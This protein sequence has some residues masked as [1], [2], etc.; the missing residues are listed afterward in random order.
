MVMLVVVTLTGCLPAQ[1]FLTTDAPALDLIQATT[2]VKAADEVKSAAFTDG[3]ADGLAGAFRGRALTNLTKQVG[4]FHKND[5]HLEERNRKAA[6]VFWDARAN[7]SV[8]EVTADHRL[9]TP[10]EPN[11]RWAATV[12][13]WWS[14]LD[15]ASGK[16]WVVDEEDLPPDKW[17]I[18]QP[19]AVAGSI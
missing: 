19:A 16:W 3:R 11:P 9:T 8:L 13:Q 12:R 15:Y 4:R 7:E 2:V 1:G 5:F 10:K 6:V 18:A 14:R 17:R